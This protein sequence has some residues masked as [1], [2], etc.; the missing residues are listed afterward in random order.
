MYQQNVWDKA[1]PSY[2]MHRIAV[3]GFQNSEKDISPTKISAAEF[4][5]S[6]AVFLGSMALVLVSRPKKK[7]IIPN[8]FKKKRTLSLYGSSFMRLCYFFGI[9]E[10]ISVKQGDG[11]GRHRSISEP[12]DL[13]PSKNTKSPHYNHY[14][15]IA[16]N[17][18]TDTGQMDIR[19]E[20]IE[21]ELVL[22]PA[23][24]NPLNQRRKERQALCFYFLVFPVI[25]TCLFVL[26]FSRASDRNLHSKPRIG[27][28]MPI[29]SRP[30][31]QISV[32]NS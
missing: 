9:K 20:S 26:S 18:L 22:S 23:E 2:S 32:L 12:F 4:L 3:V 27:P 15:Q 28:R 24:L 19:E 30:H 13:N 10:N 29:G 6:C 21:P 14:C 31:V 25:F 1:I 16:G 5:W 8:K 7:P 17:Q 11:G